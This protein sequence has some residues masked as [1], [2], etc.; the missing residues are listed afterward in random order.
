MI[1]YIIIY[2][3]PDHKRPCYMTHKGH[4]SDI[5]SLTTFMVEYCG[6]TCIENDWGSFE[7]YI[8]NKNYYCD[9]YMDNDPYKVYY[10]EN[11]EWK[12]FDLKDTEFLR[13][14]KQYLHVLN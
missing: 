10:F 7:T 12:S 2:C 13:R 8:D 3:L 11:N 14:V 4:C 9:S 1:P 6:N 5:D